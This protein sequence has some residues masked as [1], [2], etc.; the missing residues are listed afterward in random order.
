M[1]NSNT[2]SCRMKNGLLDDFERLY[3]KCAPDFVRRCLYKCFVDSDFFNSVF[4]D[5][6]IYHLIQKYE[7]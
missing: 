5:K 3:P 1:S 6:S 4:F 2:F 7:S